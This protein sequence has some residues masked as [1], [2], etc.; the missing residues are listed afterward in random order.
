MSCDKKED[1]FA[2]DNV[3]VEKD[4]VITR[5]TVLSVTQRVFDPIGFTCPVSLCPKLLLQQCWA[6][7][8]E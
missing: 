7:M 4:G 2:V 5:R 8:C 1:T 6:L 3:S